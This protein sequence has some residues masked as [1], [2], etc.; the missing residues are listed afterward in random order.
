MEKEDNCPV[1]SEFERTGKLILR[2][3]NAEE[4]IYVCSNSQCPYP[5]GLSDQ[6]T[7]NLI[8]ELQPERE[9]VQEPIASREAGKSKSHI[10]IVLCVMFVHVASLQS[11]RLLH[12]LNGLKTK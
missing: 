9:A 6:V 11:V 10:H 8:P 1:C 12:K 3:I 5:I 4:A 7:T 2:N